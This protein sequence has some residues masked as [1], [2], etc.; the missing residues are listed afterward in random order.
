[1]KLSIT[2]GKKKKKVPRLPQNFIKKCEKNQNFKTQF[3]KSDR[4]KQPEIH[5]S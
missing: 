2:F 3:L 4:Y 1:M 5:L